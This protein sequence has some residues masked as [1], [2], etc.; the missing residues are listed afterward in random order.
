VKL[1]F[2]WGGLYEMT[3]DQNGIIDKHPDVDGLY[4]AAGFSGHG[5]MMSP[6][7]GKLMSELIR[8]GKFETVDASPL[9]F[10]RFSRNEL[11]WDEAM[12]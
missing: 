10:S 1:V 11:F 9:S 8:T 5:L 4:I 12:I 2:G 6:A 7:T 3:P